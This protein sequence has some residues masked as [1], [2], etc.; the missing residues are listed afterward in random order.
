MRRHAPIDGVAWGLQSDSVKQQLGSSGHADLTGR[1]IEVHGAGA[2]A[3]AINNDGS[4]LL[5]KRADL[6]VAPINV[7]TWIIMNHDG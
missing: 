5:E 4:S 3:P 7:A 6:L 1:Q 2:C